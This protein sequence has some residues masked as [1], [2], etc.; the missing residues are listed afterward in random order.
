VAQPKSQR[1]AVEEGLRKLGGEATLKDIYAATRAIKGVTWNTQTP[2]A[3][4]RRILQTNAQFEKVVA[5]R[6]R[7][8]SQEA[9]GG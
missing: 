8:A 3:S 5:G 2:E 4:I 9:E 1:E 7:L 6:W